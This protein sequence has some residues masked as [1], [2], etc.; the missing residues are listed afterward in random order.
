MSGRDVEGCGMDTFSRRSN[1]L[2]DQMPH[3]PEGLGNGISADKQHVCWVETKNRTLLERNKQLPF[4][5]RD[6]RALVSS[7]LYKPRAQRQTDVT[8]G[9]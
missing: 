8:C 3:P 9:H 5:V 1:L 7:G 6:E 2:S 4:G